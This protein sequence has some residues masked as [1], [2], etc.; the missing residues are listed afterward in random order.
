[1]LDLVLHNG[2]IL[3]QAAPPRAEA[4][5]VRNGR[6]AHVGNNTQVMAGTT[7]RTRV[8]DLSG[9]TL[10]PGFN[11]AH[12]HIW[13]IGQLLTTMLDVRGTGS[14]DEI[15][16][17]VRA[18]ST[19]LPDGAWLLGRGYNEAALR[20]QHAPTR[21]DL[22]RADPNRPIVLTRTC[23]HM[24][25]VNSRALRLAGIDASTDAPYGGVIDRDER[26]EP[27]GVVRETAIGLI[28]RV[29]PAPSASDYERMI[30]AA[31]DHQ[32]SLGITSSSDCGVRPQILEV[33]RAL[34]ANAALPSRVN[35]M[36]LRRVDGV[37]DPVPPEP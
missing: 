30:V 33:Y 6:I 8:I 31:L 15:V 27:T 5:G 9:R 19:R 16:R 34:D 18:F 36:P 21:D 24:C 10:V 13:K 1:M 35:V 20:E 26:G 37:P 32:L 2:A 12:A 22:D 14:I 17:R 7:A 3:T 29:M 23:G 25:A 28:N 4:V 11:D